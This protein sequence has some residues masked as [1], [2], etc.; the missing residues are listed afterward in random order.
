MMHRMLHYLQLNIVQYNWSH[1]LAFLIMCMI[2]LLFVIA[3][4]DHLAL[5]FC[6]MLLVLLFCQM[7]FLSQL[8]NFF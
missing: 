6:R 4:S 7:L 1:F 5:V 3:T 8:S 2:F